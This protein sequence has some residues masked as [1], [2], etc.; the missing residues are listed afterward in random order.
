M[1]K[2]DGY[3]CAQHAAEPIAIVSAACRLPGHISSPHKLWELLQSGGIA[4]SN[5]VPNSRFH[6][7]G[8]FDGSGRPGTLK[9]LSGMFIEDID[10][11]RF[12]APFFNL[13]KA[14]ATAMDPQQRQLLEVVYECFENGGVTIERVNGKQIGCFVGSYTVGKRS[15]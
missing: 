12:D 1:P 2:V 11:A 7:D 5:N 10:P 14:D 8:H 6:G 4:V 13:T 3:A 15:E 9:A